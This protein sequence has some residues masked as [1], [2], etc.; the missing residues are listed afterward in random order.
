[1]GTA[2]LFT[3]ASTVVAAM[4][5]LLGALAVVFCASPGAGLH[6]FLD[7]LLAAGLLRLATA[8]TWSA[9]ATAAAVVAIRKVVV[10]RLRPYTV[11]TD[12]LGTVSTRSA[13]R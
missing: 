3:A 11:A 2:E 8:D 4:A 5:L 13:P 6:V 1:M 9:L 7:L 12:Q 10:Y